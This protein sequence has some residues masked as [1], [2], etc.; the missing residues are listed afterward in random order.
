MRFLLALLAWSIEYHTNSP[1]GGPE[2]LEFGAFAA[3]A[4]PSTDLGTEEGP[5]EV[6]TPCAHEAPY[7]FSHVFLGFRTTF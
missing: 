2:L 1:P 4:Q 5:S 7:G 6:E 3:G